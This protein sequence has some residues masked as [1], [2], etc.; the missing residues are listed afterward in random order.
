M[1]E[2]TPGTPSWIDLA[3]PDPDASVTFYGELFGWEAT[4]PGPVEETGGYRM[5]QQDGGTV[6][7]LMQIQQE[8]QP[9]WWSTYISVTDADA[10]ATAVKDNGG[11]VHVEPMD[12]MDIGR[13]AYFA[14]PGGAVFGVWQP[15]TF[16]GADVVNVPNSLTWNDLRTRDAEGAK[17]FYGA[18]FGW[19]PGA[20]PEGSAEYW[21]WNLDGRPV[22][23]V[24]AM[25]T[26]FPPEVPAHWGICFAV[27]DTDAIVAR[28]QELG[29]SVTS[30]P[31]D[32]PLGRWAGLADPHGA[33]FAVIAFAP[34][35]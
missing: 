35:S 30:E 8:G 21:V 27:A 29:G 25:G 2:Y 1:P 12:V 17:A 16:A 23:G 10:T 18:V 6:G 34:T 5:F 3:T 32:M 11:T 31:T 26:S 13:M 28:A 14:D 15:K 7:G 24:L 19:E 4:E 20:G 33:P 22:A 9:P